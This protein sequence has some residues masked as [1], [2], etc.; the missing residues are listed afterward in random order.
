MANF[1]RIAYYL[2]T[3]LRRL[4]WKS[5]RLKEY[6]DRRVRAVVR[7][8]YDSVPFYH[9]RFK[10]HGVSPEDIKKVKT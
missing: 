9:E 3:G 5:S 10:R 4:H 6:Q 1:A 2:A 8:A 7:H